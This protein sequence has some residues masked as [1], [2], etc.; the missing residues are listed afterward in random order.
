MHL[1][2]KMY[3][4]NVFVIQIQQFKKYYKHLNEF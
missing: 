2:L 1:T 4:Y 3:M